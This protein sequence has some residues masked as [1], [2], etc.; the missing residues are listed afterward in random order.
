LVYAAKRK[1]DNLDVAI[2]VISKAT[3]PYLNS[4]LWKDTGKR[5][6]ESAGKNVVSLIE[7][8]EEDGQLFL[9]LER[10][11]LS[12]SPPPCRFL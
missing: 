12:C 7:E 11:S 10:F 1:S 2:K 8:I 3:A 6:S 9:V 5:I 4:T